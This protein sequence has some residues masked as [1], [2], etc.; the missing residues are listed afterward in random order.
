MGIGAH[1]GGV[2]RG[3]LV[4]DGAMTQAHRIVVGV[5]GCFVLGSLGCADPPP[6][7]PVSEVFDDLEDEVAVAPAAEVKPTLAGERVDP[8]AGG[9][10]EVGADPSAAPAAALEAQADVVEPAAA[11]EGAGAAAVEKPKTTKRAAAASD[12][13]SAAAPPPTAEAPKPAE[14][15]KPAEAPTSGVDAGGG[16]KVDKVVEPASPK[17]PPE[18]P[19]ARFAGTF[20]FSGGSA[21]RAEVEAAIEAAAQQMSAVIRGIARKRLTES[22]PIR[23]AITIAVAG[24]EMTV[25]FAPG[26][27]VKG[28]LGGPAV[29]WTSDSGKPVTVAFSMVK[30]RFVMNFTAEDGSRRAVFSLDESGAKM[31]MSVT[32]SSER[33]ETP[34]K[35]ALSY[36]RR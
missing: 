8:S 10:V 32:I 14:T 5:L 25:T 28:R 11:P 7:P 24:E 15:P 16:E 31:T 23:D 2:A 19:Q 26:R 3:D 35:Y 6:P 9:E 18:P 12:G 13:R 33:L 36:S 4:Y 17:P 22:N 27:T 34:M 20:G 21:Q 29:A 30:G 1:F